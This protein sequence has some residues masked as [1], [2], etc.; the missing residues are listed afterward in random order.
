MF[1]GLSGCQKFH[2]QSASFAR[3]QKFHLLLASSARCQKFHLQSASFARC[4]K[5][6]LQ[7]ASFASGQKFPLRPLFL[8]P[9]ATRGLTWGGC[10][11]DENRRARW[12]QPFSL[13]AVACKC[14][15]RPHGIGY[16]C[17]RKK[18]HQGSTSPSVALPL[19]PIHKVEGGALQ[20]KAVCKT[21]NLFGSQRGLHAFSTLS[22]GGKGRY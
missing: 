18:Q 8:W 10:L 12:K 16:R 15:P 19:P 17:L 22:L 21:N 7:S 13:V 1:A 11:C 6:H 20:R 14:R 5:F 2:L 4:Q 3:C 9:R